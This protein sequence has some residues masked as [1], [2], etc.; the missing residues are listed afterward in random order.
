MQA[1]DIADDFIL[2][3]LATQQGKWSS[4]FKGWGDGGLYTLG[5]PYNVPEKVLLAKMRSL[6]KRGLVGGC[7]CGGYNCL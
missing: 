5:V 4:H 7:P 2:K 3:L 6:H 1:K